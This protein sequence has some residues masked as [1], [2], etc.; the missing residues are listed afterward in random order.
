MN[1]FTIKVKLGVSYLLLALLVLIGG[2]AGYMSTGQMAGALGLVSGPVQGTSQAIATGIKGVQMQMMAVEKALRLGFDKAKDDLALGKEFTNQAYE[3]ITQHGMVS[4][5]NLDSLDVALADFDN[6]SNALLKIDKEYRSTYS[7]ISDNFDK[8][9]DLLV[10]VE[11]Y[12]SQLLVNKEWNA[13]VAVDEETDTRDSDEWAVTSATTE[14]RLALLNRL[15]IYRRLI[16]DPDNVDTQRAANAAY[17]DFLIYTEEIGDSTTMEGQKL[18]K[19]PFKGKSYKDALIE[20]TKEHKALFQ[21]GINLN[22]QLDAKRQDYRKTADSLLELAKQIENEAS[23]SIQS[24]ITKAESAESQATLTII[25]VVLVSLAIAIA[26]FI[27]NLRTIVKPIS[28]VAES[29]RDIAEGEGDLTVRLDASGKDEVAC[30]SRSF[31]D[32]VEKIQQTV[33]QVASSVQKLTGSADQLNCLTDNGATRIHAQQD[34][35]M[36]VSQTMQEMVASF[37]EVAESAEHALQSATDAEREVSEGRNIVT[38]T[39]EAIDRLAR[40]VDSATETI[41]QLEKQSDDIGG[42]LDVIGGIAEQTNLLALNAAIEA[43][44]AGDQG[45]GFAV[46]ADEV[47]TLASRTQESTEE[48]QKMIERLQTGARNAASVMT[49]SRSKAQDTVSEGGKADES[50]S[51]ILQAVSSIHGMNQQIASA[52]EEQSVTAQT[53]SSN[54]NKINDAGGEIVNDIGEMSNSTQSLNDLSKQ[55]DG[56]VKQFKV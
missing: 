26:A 49:E 22:N 48:I 17:E 12:A 11:E 27:V 51:R 9:L 19:G 1:Q 31:N 40:Q 52:A 21:K 29:L 28:E 13:D 44:R 42:V 39:L 43:A 54:V 47:R 46:V 10:N 18:E 45:R 55:L 32:F 35:T 23:A 3:Q 4:K 41:Q 6:I 8:T 15:Y 30:L 5:A 50:L 53:I 25:S 34:D 36:M 37:T 16:E 14:S 56:L 33:I 20:S 7:G 24:E 2:I 38:G